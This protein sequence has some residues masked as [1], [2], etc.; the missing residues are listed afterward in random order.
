MSWAAYIGRRGSL[1]WGM[2][3]EWE[4][5]KQRALFL[6]WH[7]NRKPGTPPLRAA[8]LMEHAVEV[9]VA[10][11]DDVLKEMRVKVRK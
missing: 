1:N 5:A 2:R 8:D 9:P 3:M 10:S 7:P 6:N 4:S 11:L